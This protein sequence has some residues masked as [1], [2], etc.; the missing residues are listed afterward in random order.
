[1]LQICTKTLAVSLAVLCIASTLAVAQDS[2]SAEPSSRSSGI[3][4]SGIGVDNGPGAS[5]GTTAR[6]AT[7]AGSGTSGKYG[8][9]AGM[10]RAGTTG[11]SGGTGAVVGDGGNESRSPGQVGA[12]DTRGQSGDRGSADTSNVWKWDVVG[13]AK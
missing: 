10:G 6:D 3:P 8:T 7:G 11:A 5:P 4:S 12:K 2:G 9:G 13:P 1:M